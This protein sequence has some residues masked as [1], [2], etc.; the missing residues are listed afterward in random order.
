MELPRYPLQSV[1][2]VNVYDEAGNATAVVVATVFDVDAQQMPGRIALKSGQT[3]P[4]ATREINAIELTYISGYGDAASDVPAPL[5]RAIRSMVAY[6]YA[7]RGDDCDMG[8][9][10]EASGAAKV[11]GRYRVVKI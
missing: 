1:S 2:G 5:K 3:W 10:Y 4:I 8:D 7:H 11:A 9:A 6:V